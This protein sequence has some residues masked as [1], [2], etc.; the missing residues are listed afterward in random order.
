MDVKRYLV[1]NLQQ[2]SFWVAM[3]PPS[4]EG[5]TIA[6]WLKLKIQ[7]TMEAADSRLQKRPPF[8]AAFGPVSRVIPFRLNFGDVVLFN[9]NATFSAKLVSFGT[10]SRFDHVGIVVPVPPH[11]SMGLMEATKSGVYAYPLEERYLN[12]NSNLFF[13][14]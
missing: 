5:P 4:A 13:K 14:I 3:R 6:A 10:G 12:F 9:N 8:L 7:I 2:P 11:D 1:Q